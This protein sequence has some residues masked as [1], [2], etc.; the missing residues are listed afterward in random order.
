MQGSTKAKRRGPGVHP[1]RAEHILESLE[2]L[3][4]LDPSYNYMSG[5][6]WALSKKGRAFLVEKKLL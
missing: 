5:T 2:D 4:L 1:Q 3:K 6:S